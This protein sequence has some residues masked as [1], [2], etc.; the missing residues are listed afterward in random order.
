MWEHLWGKGR[1]GC[2]LQETKIVQILVEGF[3]RLEVRTV[4]YTDKKI[5]ISIHR[6]VT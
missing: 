6:L 4:G 5:L 1:E 3:Y 2:V